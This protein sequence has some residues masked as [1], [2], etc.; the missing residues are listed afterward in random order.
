MSIV[1]DYVYTMPTIPVAARSKAW[2]CG[3]SLA[4]IVGSNPTGGID[5]SLSCECYVLSGRGL[6]ESPI[7]H[8]EESYWVRYVW[9]CS[10][11]LDNK[12]VLVHEGHSRHG[13]KKY[14][15]LRND[16]KGKGNVARKQ[17]K[18]SSAVY[19]VIRSILNNVI[20][21][22]PFPRVPH[23]WLLPHDVRV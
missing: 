1:L 13:K 17:N 16:Q 21:G 7:T 18:T 6:C 8:T 12:G 15:M 2:V 23:K 10:W 9:E 22:Q 14:T 3:R 19:T 20:S 5:V 4:G 11:S